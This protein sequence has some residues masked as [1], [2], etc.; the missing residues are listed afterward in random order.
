[1]EEWI[2]GLSWQTL[3]GKA[4]D[5]GISSRG[6]AYVVSQNSRIWRWRYEKGWQ[7]LP[8]DFKRLTV[9]ADQKPW[10]IDRN[11][12]CRRY[13][14]LWWDIF[15]KIR[16]LDI[17]AGLD[18]TVF[19]L[20]LHGA[21]R[22]WHKQR[23]YWKSFS[24]EGHSFKD[25]PARRIAVDNSGNP[26][27]ILRDN[28]ILRYTD[29]GW[30]QLPGKADDIAIGDDNTVVIVTVSGVLSIYDNT[31]QQWLAI[32]GTADSVSVAVGTKGAPWI[33]K[34]DGTIVVGTVY[35]S[36]NDSKK[37]QDNPAKAVPDISKQKNIA[38][39]QAAAYVSLQ[40]SVKPTTQIARF[41]FKLIPGI[42][43]RELG[44]GAD[45]S[46]YLVDTDGGVWR[47]SN[48]RLSFTSFP[49]IL[50]SVAVD[51]YGL[52]WGINPSGQV[53]RH[54]DGDWKQVK[55]ITAADIAIGVNGQVMVS[56]PADNIFRYNSLK[57][58]FEKIHGNVSGR[59]IAVDADG[60]LWTVRSNGRVYY[61]PEQQCRY[62]GK[63][64]GRDIAVGPEGS[65][66]L[67][68]QDNKLYRWN[69]D[70]ERWDKK[71]DAAY[72]VSV[73]PEGYP[74]VLDDQNRLFRTVFFSRDEE[75][76]LITALQTRFETLTRDKKTPTI[77]FNKNFR[78]QEIGISGFYN[79]TP[80]VHISNGADDAI[81]IIEETDIG[82]AVTTVTTWI[83]SFCLANPTDVACYN[84]VANCT[85]PTGSACADCNN[86]VN[87]N[88]S[89]CT[90][91]Q[92]PVTGSEWLNGYCLV[93]PSDP[94]CTGACVGQAGCVDCSIAGAQIG[95]VCV[96]RGNGGSVSTPIP[97][98][99]IFQYHT[100]ARKFKLI[101]RTPN[102]DTDWI[103]S[104]PDGRRWAIDTNNKTYRERSP[105][106]GSYQEIRSTVPN[107]TG[108][109]GRRVAVGGDGSVF[110]LND[111]G[112]LYR[113][114]SKRKRFERFERN[115]TFRRVAL[116]PDG[117]LWVINNLG[118]LQRYVDAHVYDLPKKAPLNADEIAIGANGSVYIILTES[119]SKKVKKYNAV[120][121]RFDN[122]SLPFAGDPVE[123]AVDNTGRLLVLTSTSKIYRAK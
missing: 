59:R 77:T 43:G 56:T 2:K 82:Q 48:G 95:S 41:I 114:N 97:N 80:S 94:N 88:I 85:P 78:F 69:P 31:S 24:E 83:N 33:I 99:F 45:G 32:P 115:R 112:E 16:I 25:H 49:G 70:T 89:Q 57:D 101:N 76:D 102:K 87:Q 52:P 65:V 19:A 40:K 54:V 98:N 7:L 36:P 22:R 110:A 6:V 50:K 12:Y 123:I 15:G 64:N 61:C 26:W 93:N 118:K 86:P 14:G 47:W 1:L 121:D 74:W 79:A 60:W 5:V 37:Q 28:H 18:G 73:G 4:I 109:N 100:R 96:K 120:S 3:N 53:F 23:R 27:V 84:I 30:Q 10:A 81:F 119:G 46:I 106:R 92:D 113:Y 20:D 44:I 38:M 104:A 58:R 8:G 117:N 122:V 67:T 63:S 34:K 75:G 51:P 68:T 107:V 103:V 111:A 39:Q 13:N 42:S 17:S 62:R 108:T 71:Y 90:S 55:K 105:G 9:G 29:S 72:K 66:F 91:Y 11:D 116:D 21:P 35:L